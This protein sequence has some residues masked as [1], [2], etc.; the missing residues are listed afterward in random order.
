LPK[1]KFKDYPIG[2]L[3]IDFAKVHT[4]QGNLYLFVAIDR[5]S[6]V[7]FAQLHPRAT[8]LVAAEFL[9]RALAYFPYKPIKY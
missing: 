2:Y 4:Q 7:G 3:P 6:K 5:T 9:R 1:N 8:K